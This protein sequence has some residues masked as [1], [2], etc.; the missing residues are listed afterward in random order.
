[1]AETGLELQVTKLET[2]AALAAACQE[3][4]VTFDNVDDILESSPDL[5]GVLGT[6]R[7]EIRAVFDT[8]RGF[9]DR[10]HDARNDVSRT[11]KEALKT[12]RGES[13]QLPSLPVLRLPS[14]LRRGEYCGTSEKATMAR[15]LHL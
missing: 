3:V 1:M 15:P 6:S 12:T 7:E 14:H 8:L 5:L 11:L 10:A 13:A 2:L 9:S 4:V